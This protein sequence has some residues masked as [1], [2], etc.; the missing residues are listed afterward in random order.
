METPAEEVDTSVIDELKSGLP[1]HLGA[2]RS[3]GERSRKSH[4]VV[5]RGRGRRHWL[6]HP[7]GI[8]GPGVPVQQGRTLSHAHL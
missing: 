4:R 3:D 5:H 8:H 2:V 1:T 7:A 6:A